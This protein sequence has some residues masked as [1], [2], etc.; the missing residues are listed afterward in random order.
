M[1]RV[2]INV[3]NGTH[4][5][6]SL[7][8]LPLDVLQL[9][10]SFLPTPATL[11]TVAT[12]SSSFAALAQNETYWQNVWIQR[13]S[14]CFRSYV[15]PVSSAFA[16][17][18][19]GCWGHVVSLVSA[20]NQA[21]PR[22]SRHKCGGGGGVTIVE[23]HDDSEGSV[24]HIGLCIGP[25]LL[26]A[27]A[28][29]D[30]AALAYHL[31]LPTRETSDAPVYGKGAEVGNASA[32]TAGVRRA[33]QGSHSLRLQKALFFLDNAA[34]LGVATG[35]R[36]MIDGL[37]V[38]RLFGFEVGLS[39]PHRREGT[40]LEQEA[41]LGE[42]V[43]AL[44]YAWECCH[45]SLRPDISTKRGLLPQAEL[46]STSFFLTGGDEDVDVGEMGDIHLGV[47]F[48]VAA[49][50]SSSSSSSLS[51]DTPQ[52][53]PAV[54]SSDSALIVTAA[55][56]AAGTECCLCHSLSDTLMYLFLLHHVTFSDVHQH[57]WDDERKCAICSRVLGPTGQAVEFRFFVSSLRGS[58]PRFFVKMMFAEGD[59]PRTCIQET[60]NRESSRSTAFARFST[61]AEEVEPKLTTLFYG[62]FG[63][64]EVDCPP[65]VSREGFLRLRGAL[66]LAPAFPMQLLWN[67]VLLATGVGGAALRTQAPYFAL[68]YQTSFTAAFD[69]L[70]PP[71][72]ERT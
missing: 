70:F 14:A 27:A 63:R 5:K 49:S 59:L 42:F 24:T 35:R 44:V 51:F 43:S 41:A 53:L 28:P 4:Q 58:Y 65:T 26:R 48:P 1:T 47:F 39:P 62:G 6:P 31:L 68:H 37:H 55:S 22:L 11:R 52:A 23:E 13:V 8:R 56:A 46:Q 30:F 61:S 7:S 40:L 66:G 29:V 38:I 19:A 17:S 2:G 60:F 36:P 45:P 54:A 10:L 3:A 18:D 21:L 20:P 33:T 64:V 16:P 69:E 32:A 57:V 34:S 72:P 67:V 25:L 9:I 50:L 71:A 12:L 15:Q